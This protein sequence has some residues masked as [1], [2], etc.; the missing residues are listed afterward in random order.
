MGTG[1]SEAHY[2]VDMEE[3]IAMILEQVV[4]TH[5]CTQL[6]QCLEKQAIASSWSNHSDMLTWMLFV[7]AMAYGDI[8]NWGIKF[9]NLDCNAPGP[10]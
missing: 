9:R 4:S 2:G 7:A 6:Q 10:L 8:Q 5:L 1:Y 3:W